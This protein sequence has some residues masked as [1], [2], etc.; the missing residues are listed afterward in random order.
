MSFDEEIKSICLQL[1]GNWG[2]G[3]TDSFY[4]F[5]FIDDIYGSARL[6]IQDRKGN[7]RSLKYGIT[8]YKLAG[9]PLRMIYMIETL[10]NRQIQYFAILELSRDKLELIRLKDLMS[11]HSSMHLFRPLPDVEFVEYLLEEIT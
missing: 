3:R 1:V 4:T 2:D 6:Y 8:C 10:E 9:Q 5:D 11:L 7:I